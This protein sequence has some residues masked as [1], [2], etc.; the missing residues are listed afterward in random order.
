MSE[1]AESEYDRSSIAPSQN[2][3]QYPRGDGRPRRAE[4]VLDK[5]KDLKGIKESLPVKF[6]DK[7]IKKKM[8]SRYDRIMPVIGAKEGGISKILSQKPLFTYDEMFPE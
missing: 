4:I 1:N 7:E 2:A 6:D 5:N 8:K 3:S